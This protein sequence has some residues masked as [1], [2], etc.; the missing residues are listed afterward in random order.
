[1]WEDDSSCLCCHIEDGFAIICAPGI[2]YEAF[3]LLTD[4]EGG[5]IF[6]Y[7]YS[8]Y[9]V[10][11]CS[12]FPTRKERKSGKA[13][14][15]LA[16]RHH[17]QSYGK[18]RWLR[19]KKKGKLIIIPYQ[20]M[21]PDC[22]QPPPKCCVLILP[23]G[24]ASRQLRESCPDLAPPWVQLPRTDTGHRSKGKMSTPRSAAVLTAFRKQ[25]CGITGA[26]AG[27]NLPDS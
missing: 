3:T 1:M 12:A 20:T 19:K 5:I 22:T 24:A 23:H 10:Q 4:S 27:A 9:F 13:G 16:V 21:W 2:L 26:D 18:G 15:E 17:S 25:R 6:H 8:K 11:S 14:A 7:G